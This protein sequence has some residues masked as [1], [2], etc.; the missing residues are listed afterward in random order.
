MNVDKEQN[1]EKQW[2]KLKKAKTSKK[3]AKTLVMEKRMDSLPPPPAPSSQQSLPK[4][5]ENV[6][7]LESLFKMQFPS[8]LLAAQN[9]TPCPPAVSFSRKQKRI[10]W[11]VVNEKWIMKN[12]S[13]RMKSR[14]TIKTKI[15]K[16]QKSPPPLPYSPPPKSST[17]KTKKIKIKSMTKLALPIQV[18]SISKKRAVKFIKWKMVDG[19]WVFKKIIPK[20][21]TIKAP[22]PKL[23]PP[24]SPAVPLEQ[25]NVEKIMIPDEIL[26][27]SPPPKQEKSQLK[28]TMDKSINET[29]SDRKSTKMP[30]PKKQFS[31][32]KSI[33]DT[34]IKQEK[35]K[36]SKMEK[37]PEKELPI[38]L[39]TSTE[40]ILSSESLPSSSQSFTSS[41]KEKIKIRLQ[42]KKKIKAKCNDLKKFDITT[43]S[44]SRPPAYEPGPSPT[45]L[46]IKIKKLFKK[47]LSKKSFIPTCRIP[48]ALPSIDSIKEKLKLNKLMQE[49]FQKLKRSTKMRT[50]KRAKLRSKRLL[51]SAKLN[52]PI[53]LARLG[54]KTKNISRK[55]QSK[56]KIEM[57]E[58]P[59]KEL[60]L[61]MSKSSSPILKEKINEKTILKLIKKMDLAMKKSHS[62]ELVQAPKT[63]KSKS[64]SNKFDDSFR[65]VQQINASKEKSNRSPP[66]LEYLIKKQLSIRSKF[67]VN[68]P[69]KRTS[70]SSSSPPKSD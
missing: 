60:N 44:K 16:Q 5:N 14:K 65:L 56:L 21:K 40:S 69:P 38:S 23:S 66:P 61:K 26:K 41:L 52:T 49:S 25:S 7:T 15:N 2:E 62:I 9:L 12:L 17:I 10:K 64:I 35:I 11:M 3:R 30:S 67:K 42:S 54:R 36:E 59:K 51:K 58:S 8:K 50:P 34:E 6:V 20:R 33:S 24:P 32:L 19:E 1:G 57:E 43:S 31:P 4:V 37:L 39:K 28:K 27:L 13:K 22:I 70:S 45:D 47:E 46:E 53:S 63:I 18:K 48:K 68:L 29:K 55:K